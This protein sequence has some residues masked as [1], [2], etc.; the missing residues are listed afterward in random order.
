MYFLGC[1]IV[2]IFDFVGKNLISISNSAL[3]IH[4]Q[5]KEQLITELLFYK[6]AATYSPT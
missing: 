3:N 1:K 5:K 4:K 2:I 6:K